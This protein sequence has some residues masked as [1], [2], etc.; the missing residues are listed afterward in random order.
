M[1][2]KGNKFTVR[3]AARFAV[4]VAII[5]KPNIHHVAATSLPDS[6]RGASPPPTGEKFHHQVG[7]MLGCLLAFWDFFSALPLQ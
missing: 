7:S 3:K 5:M 4:Y 2:H 1:T 6:A